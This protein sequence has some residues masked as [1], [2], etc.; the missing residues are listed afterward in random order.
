[1]KHLP[2]P[3]L[4]PACR[5]KLQNTLAKQRQSLNLTYCPHNATLAKVVLETGCIVRWE[6]ARPVSR[7]QAAEIMRCQAEL[8]TVVTTS[9]DPGLTH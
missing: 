5:D 8:A 4:C 1:M 2:P 6:M 9:R 7:A 3:S